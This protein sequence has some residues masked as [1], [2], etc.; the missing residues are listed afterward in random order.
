[1][2]SL[3]NAFLNRM[4]A[5]LGVSF[6]EY[7][8]AM[9]KPAL[10]AFRANGIKIRTEELCSTLDFQFSPVPGV[11]GAWFFPDSVQIGRHPAHAAGL[12]Y[13]QE[14]SAQIPISQLPLFP[15]MRVLDLCA[16]PGGKSGQI[17]EKSVQA[18][19]SFPTNRSAP[20]QRSSPAIWNALE[21]HGSLLPA[22]C[23]NGSVLC[24]PVSLMRLLWMRHVP[25]KECSERI[26][27][28][29]GN[30]QK[31]PFCP[32]QSVSVPS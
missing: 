25:V 12:L 4:K 5:Q 18:V 31:N 6:P 8:Q 24:S 1:M 14:P 11:P 26:P 28:Q 20:V 3:P 13:V 9:E 16:A 19:S 32:A 2:I 17:A 10:R 30:G 7:L 27:M 29:F 15:G 22:S 23:R 21:L